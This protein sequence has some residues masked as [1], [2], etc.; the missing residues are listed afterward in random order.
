M[1]DDKDD[2]YIE[3]GPIQ[4]D[5]ELNNILDELSDGQD[6]VEN[7][8]PGTQPKV[9]LPAIPS[10]AETKPIPV[11]PKV[12]EPAQNQGALELA[13]LLKTF[14]PI[15]QD[16][17]TNYKS[18]REQIEKTVKFLEDMVFNV[19]SAGRVHIEMLVA[20]LKTKSDT[21]ISAVKLLDSLA[22]I[23]AASKG[24]SI[25]IQNNNG[26]AGSAQEELDDILDADSYPDE[27]PDA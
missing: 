12:V 8:V 14:M 1:G 20:S 10:P 15:A 23:L 13:Q 19:P 5:E 3:E 21:S 24:T 25:L 11:E 16:I 4:E 18:D 7:E 6:I 17:F 27:K 2:D 9:E 26:N 22:K